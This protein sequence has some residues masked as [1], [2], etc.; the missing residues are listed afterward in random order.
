MSTAPQF[1]TPVVE[2]ERIEEVAEGVWVIP[3]ADH[4]LLVPNVGVVVGTRATLVVDTGFGSENA[5][6]VLAAA[7]R[8]SDGRPIY[9]THTHCHPEHGFGANAIANDVTVVYNAAQWDELQEKGPIL[10]QMFRKQ[11]PPLASLLDG[12]EFVRPELLYTGSLSLD[13][14][15]PTVELFEV[16]GAHSRGDQAIVIRSSKLVLFTG[17][18]VEEGYYGI[19]GDGESHALPWIDRLNRLER[20]GAELVVPG[21]GHSGGRELIPMYRAYFEHAKRRVGE[22]RADGRLSEDEI[23]ETVAQEV[24]DLHP[25]WQ[26]KPWARKTVDDLRWPARA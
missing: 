4:T 17:D 21:H 6:L 10:L 3:D 26:N 9:L 16:G 20:L 1:K 12:V 11:I 23:A 2:P 24:L 5:R 14:G 25:G 13:L 18:L 19:L 22:L 15:G 7:K 8:L